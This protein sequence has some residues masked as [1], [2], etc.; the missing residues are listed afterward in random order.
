MGSTPGRRR[1]RT[2]AGGRPRSRR[3]PHPARGRGPPD[4]VCRLD[5]LLLGVQQLAHRR[6]PRARCSSAARSP[7]WWYGA[8]WLTPAQARDLTEADLGGRLGREQR[9][10]GVLERGLEIAVVIG[11]PDVDG[12]LDTSNILPQCGHCP[13]N[14]HCQDRSIAMTR[15][16]VLDGH[17][18]PHSLTAA[19]AREYVAGAGDDAVLLVPA[20]PRDRPPFLHQGYRPGQA[21][22]ARPRPGPRAD[23]VERA[24]H[25]A[26]AVWWGSVP[27]LLKGFLDRTLVI[28]WAFRYRDNGTPEG[29]LAGRTGR[30]HR[31]R[32]THRGG[33]SRSSAT[34]R[35]SS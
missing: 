15:T 8:L 3:R 19:L 35:S 10:R 27:A 22:R 9:Q 17:P 14:R 5:R 1:A 6:A 16:L 24:H 7:K 33:T 23:R 25:R 31:S 12:D 18:D 2:P 32:P 26:H 11:G 13:E 4:R 21:R 20:R 34:P 30:A 29:L 28:G